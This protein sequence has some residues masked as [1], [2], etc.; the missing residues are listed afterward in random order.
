M[1]G[2]SGPSPWALERFGDTAETLM[3]EIP[4]ALRDAHNRA[5]KAY[6]GLAVG[7]NEAYG[8]IWL[9]QHEELVSRLSG[10]EGTKVIKPKG[11][12]YELVMIGNVVL[13]PWRYADETRQP[14]EY[15]RMKPSDVRRNLLALAE[16]PSDDQLTLDT[17]EVDD[18]ELNAEY[19]QVR[20]ALLEMAASVRLVVVAY[21]SNPRSGILTVEWGDASQADD[22][23]HLDWIYH[24]SL[25]VASAGEGGGTLAIPLRP[26]APAGG[27]SVSTRR[28]D[29][30]P[31]AE[32]NLTPKSPLINV[33][34]E[35]QPPIEE[36][37]SDD[38]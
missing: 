5:L 12:R 30:A 36:T 31:L 14:L 15:A 20:Q 23:G 27:S 10:I 17:V 35:Q 18:A 34:S 25:P 21:A 6:Q 4:A 32:P 9:A 16:R 29:D 37:G 22:E 19:E 26:I 28:F 3:R 13:Y 1:G 38:D 7:T 24:E 2:S 33:D 8:L 11:A